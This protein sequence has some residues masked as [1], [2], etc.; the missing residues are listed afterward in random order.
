M[1]PVIIIVIAISII[2]LLIAR[3][4]PLRFPSLKSKF[5]YMEEDGSV[6]ELTK[7]EKEYLNEDFEYNDGN[8]PY[9][10]SNYWQKTPDNKKDGF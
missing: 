9:I 4:F 1:H 3:T 8:R 7:D 10:K 2:A 5:V 6:R